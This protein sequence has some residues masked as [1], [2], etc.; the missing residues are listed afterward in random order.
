VFVWVCLFACLLVGS[1][2]K[3]SVNFYYIFCGL[4]SSATTAVMVVCR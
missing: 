3:L 2:K 1:L 4:V